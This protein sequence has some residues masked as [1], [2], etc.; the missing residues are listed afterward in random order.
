MG[1][2]DSASGARVMD[3]WEVQSA[4]QF[5]TQVLGK[6]EVTGMP[7]DLRFKGVQQDQQKVRSVRASL[8]PLNDTLATCSDT[9]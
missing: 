8:R 2:V 1:D 4:S 6:G 3:R 7:V 9:M 5:F